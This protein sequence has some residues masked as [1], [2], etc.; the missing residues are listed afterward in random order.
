MR[1]RWLCP[2]KRAVLGSEYGKESMN[3]RGR[4][5]LFG[6]ALQ[7][8]GLGAVFT[9]LFS[10]VAAGAGA[11]PSSVQGIL[12]RAQAAA[13]AFIPPFPE[14]P[15]T[16]GQPS[17]EPSPSASPTVA[18][19]PLATPTPGPLEIPKGGPLQVSLLGSL[20]AGRS[21]N[22]SS[23]GG[24]STA[25][26]LASEAIGLT[27]E[28][29]RHTASSTADIRL[30]LGVGN[31]GSS[32]GLP[33]V[34]YA[35]PKYL[36]SFGQQQTS[37]FGV[38]PAGSTPRGYALTTGLG[39]AGDLTL[40]GGIA[41]GVNG[42]GIR[43]LALRGRRLSGQSLY[44][45][46]IAQGSAGEQTGA[47]TLLT[48]G[49]ATSLHNMSFLAEAALQD[50]NAPDKRLS[51]F[52]YGV[53][54]DQGL[55]NNGSTFVLNVLPDR[56]L[57]YGAGEATGSDVGDFSI[58]RYYG[59]TNLALDI[60]R[61][62][63]FGDGLSATSTRENVSLGG[64]LLGR[65]QYSLNLT[66]SKTVGDQPAQWNGTGQLQFA[67]PIQSGFA[68]FGLQ[69]G[70]QLQDGASPASGVAYT[71]QLQRQVGPFAFS[72]G[73][74]RSRQTGDQGVSQTDIFTTGLTR[75]F[76]RT[77]VGFTYTQTRTDSPTTQ[78]LSRTPLLLLTRQISPALSVQMQYGTQIFSDA[79]NPSADGRSRLFSIQLNAPFQF[80]NTGV[81]GR[82]DPRLPATITGRVL[83]DV[84]NAP[85]LVAAAGSGGIG[86]ISVVLDGQYVQ[87]TDFA[88][89]FSFPFVKAGNHQLR[90]DTTSIPRG[91]SVDQPVIMVHIDGGQTGQYVFRIGNYGAVYGH[92][93]GNSGT[94]NATPLSGVLLRLDGG[95]YSQTDAQ[96][97]YGFGHLTPGDHTITVIEESV[98]AFAAFSKAQLERKF[99]IANGQI[100]TLDFVADPL[101]SIAGTVKFD[102]TLKAEGYAGGAT[103]AYVVAEP[104]EH[105]AIVGDDGSYI[106][107]NLLPGTYTISVDS[108]TLPDPQ[109]GPLEPDYSETLVGHENITGV[110]FRIGHKIKHVVFSFV[111]GDNGA[112]LTVTLSEPRLPPLGTAEASVEAPQNLPRV[113]VA[114]FGR[115]TNATYDPDRKAW[116]GE[117]AVPVDAK[118]GKATVTASANGKSASTEIIV[119]PKTP[120]A[121][122]QIT[123]SAPQ[124]NEY[125]AVRGRFLVDVAEG[126]RIVWDD[127]QITTLSKPVSGRVF[128]FS[129][130]LTHRPLQGTLFTRSGKFAVK[131]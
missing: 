116:I 107:D 9:G 4:K 114:A 13:V 56:F 105:A 92:V 58:H 117:I 127:G 47:S 53:R 7:Y 80:G 50:R 131:V 118:P 31:H 71:G 128:A 14:L 72:L 69:A 23:I 62:R 111:Q 25:N 49:I 33:T 91:L 32:F 88:G 113:T 19:S 109:I 54:V 82:V 17:P 95:A 45:F 73:E 1:Q 104:G 52:A 8:A 12:L 5:R 11:T 87:R 65:A 34:S 120:L 24:V 64:S 67:I 84:G 68:L 70:R 43:L 100:L 2:L 106:I 83:S 10:L 59:R 86:N 3:L 79:L 115:T 98:P 108:E 122:L 37:L 110:D 41:S 6:R 130:H 74:Q 20:T 29:S 123:T 99:S 28:L 15:L 60:G 35:R 93:L 77:G 48:A 90:I 38:I 44:E 97:N 30:P 96:G 126:D 39:S 55:G 57:L 81:Q 21:F 42:E 75:N 18:P 26:A 78:A 61:Q 89:N 119:D 16:P 27:A 121:T 51:Q 103:N 36:L 46:G 101:G 102:P 76:R 125:V 85:G 124:I 66:S 112:P 129:V 40:F 94:G 22:D 63:T